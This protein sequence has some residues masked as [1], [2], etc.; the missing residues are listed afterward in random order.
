MS[1]FKKRS[2]G[3]STAASVATRTLTSRLTYANVASTI[4]LFI[5]LGGTAYA[6]ASITGKDVKDGSLTSADIK[7]H[8]LRARDLKAGTLRGGSAGSAIVTG[9][10]GPKGDAGPAGPK[11]DRGPAG[12]AGD[13]GPAPLPRRTPVGR[14]T[15][16]GI[17]G[18]GPGGTVLVRSLAWSNELTGDPFASGGGATAQPRWGNVVV[19]KGADAGSAELWK[20]TATG[21][22][23]ASAKLEL[24]EPGASAPYA[25]YVFKDVAT[26]RFS[27]R[28]S[29][30]ERRDEVRLSFSPAA[31]AFSFDAAAPLPELADPRVGQMTVDGLTATPTS[32]SMPGAWP[33]PGRPGSTSSWSAR[34][35]TPP[36]RRY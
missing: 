24:L 5:V 6:A 10:A 22:R 13:H 1:L 14:L 32:R 31:P 36:R 17:S 18:D 12:A 25:S 2:D 21:Q 3:R 11:G 35:L 20:R 28:G 26:T 16:P 27:T 34:V 23:V 15:L 7:D 19:A 9:P 33:T 4:C 30:A 29:G 8:S